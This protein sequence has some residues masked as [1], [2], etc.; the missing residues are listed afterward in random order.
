MN[1]TPEAIRALEIFFLFFELILLNGFTSRAFLREEGP[2]LFSPPE[3]L[4][5][6]IDLF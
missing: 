3:G 5:S 1:I 2:S 6:H 4:K